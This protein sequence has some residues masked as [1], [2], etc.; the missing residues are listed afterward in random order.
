MV[1]SAKVEIGTRTG[2][3]GLTLLVLYYKNACGIHW[4][5]Y[6]NRA[7]IIMIMLFSRESN[8]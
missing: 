6:R 8:A 2:R 7:S 1:I 5:T 4:Q 3:D